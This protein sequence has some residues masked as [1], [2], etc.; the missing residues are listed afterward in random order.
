MVLLTR[1]AV[2]VASG[3]PAIFDL[4]SAITNA[5]FSSP[6]ISNDSFAVGALTG[7]SFQ[8]NSDPPSDPNRGRGTG[9]YGNPGFSSTSAM[10]GY[11]RRASQSQ[12]WISQNFLAGDVRRLYQVIT[13]PSGYAEIRL[14]VDASGRESSSFS[15]TTHQLR[16]RLNG[17]ERLTTLVEQTRNLR[18]ASAWFTPPSGPVELEVATVRTATSDSAIFVHNIRLEGRNSG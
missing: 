5:D 7:W 17:V 3:V 13:V 4:T 2:N 18:F 8:I 9:P 14:T 11:I 6:A 12:Y 10:V 16:L 15:P 1:P